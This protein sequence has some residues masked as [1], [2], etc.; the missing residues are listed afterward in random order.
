MFTFLWFLRISLLMLSAFVRI[1]W[2][3]RDSK[4]GKGD[5]AFKV[6]DLQLI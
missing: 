5:G 4:M 1:S 6:A 2:C 3:L